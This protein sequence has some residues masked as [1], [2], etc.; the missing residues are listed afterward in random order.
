MGVVEFKASLSY[1]VRPVSKQNQS[2][3]RNK[4]GL[5]AEPFAFS[6]LSR[7][8]VPLMTYLLPK[9]ARCQ[10]PSLDPSVVLSEPAIP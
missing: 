8:H 3:W 6:L 10:P 2:D 9:A 4:V 1:R 7:R 5:G